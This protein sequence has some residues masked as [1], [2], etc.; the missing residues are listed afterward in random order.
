PGRHNLNG[1]AQGPLNTYGYAN[2]PDTMGTAICGSYAPNDWGLY[3]MHGN[4]GEWC[5]DWYQESLA[6]TDGSVITTGSSNRV[7][8]SGLGSD[9][10]V[11]LR[12]AARTGND[13]TLQHQFIGFRLACRAGLK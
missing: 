7:R 8:R 3:D 11:H 1:G 2:C 4:V 10:A 6:G 12:S 5:L 9:G 13:P